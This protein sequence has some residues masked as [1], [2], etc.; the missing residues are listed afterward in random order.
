[1]EYVYVFTFLLGIP[2][3]WNILFALRFE[4]IFQK[5]KVWQIRLAYVLVSIILSHL[6]AEGINLFV[7]NI[8]ALF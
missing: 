2:L 7:N 1:M 5:G 6:L 8:Y 4:S 3:F